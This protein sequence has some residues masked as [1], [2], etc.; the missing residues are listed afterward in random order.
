MTDLN[1]HKHV[2]NI[3]CLC[4]IVISKY[5]TPTSSYLPLLQSKQLCKGSHSR[6]LRQIMKQF[7]VA[8][9]SRNGQYKDVYGR[10]A[11]ISQRTHISKANF[12]LTVHNVQCTLKEFYPILKFY[13][14]KYL[15]LDEL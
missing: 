1:E 4:R 5:R 3:Y 15:F 13:D 7:N 9:I 14:C 12:C 8:H 11:E 6:L 2:T 10:T